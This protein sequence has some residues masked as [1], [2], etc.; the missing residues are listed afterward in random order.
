[1]Q[2]AMQKHEQE[3]RQLQEW[4]QQEKISRLGAEDNCRLL[5]VSTVARVLW[6]FAYIYQCSPRFGVLFAEQIVGA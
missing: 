1:M 6:S 4:L 2:N 3:T 5:E